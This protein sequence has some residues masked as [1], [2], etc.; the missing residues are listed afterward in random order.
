MRRALRVR[1]RGYRQHGKR[2]CPTSV[3]SAVQEFA[4]RMCISSR[5]TTGRRGWSSGPAPNPLACPISTRMPL[6]RKER[7]GGCT[8]G[9]LFWPVGELELGAKESKSRS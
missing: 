6:A 9:V 4:L 5:G 3:S 8:G 7:G 1:R 2:S